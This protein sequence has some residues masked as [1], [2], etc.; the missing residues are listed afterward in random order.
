MKCAVSVAVSSVFVCTKGEQR[1]RCDATASPNGESPYETGVPD[2]DLNYS[3]SD[4]SY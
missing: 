2:V 4:N 1:E 3:L